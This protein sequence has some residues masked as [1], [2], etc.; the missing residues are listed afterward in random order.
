MIQKYTCW[1]MYTERV[2]F[3][4]EGMRSSF[5]IS[6]GAGG[7]SDG[8]PRRRS[9]AVGSFLLLAW[10]WTYEQ[11]VQ[12]QVQTC[13]SRARSHRRKTVS[14]SVSR[15][16]QGLRQVRKPQDSQTN[17]HRF[18]AYN[19]SCFYW[20]WNYRSRSGSLEVC[21]YGRDFLLSWFPITRYGILNSRPILVYVYIRIDSLCICAQDYTRLERDKQKGQRKRT[22]DRGIYPKGG[23]ESNIPHFQKWGLTDW[24][25]GLHIFDRL[26]SCC[27]RHPSDAYSKQRL[28]EARFV[29]F[30]LLINEYWYE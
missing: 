13:Q 2:I 24:S 28:F 30:F 26:A 4:T 1:C 7:T 5:R 3:N 21:W 19:D 14:L 15:L 18:V 23:W 10:M 25:L 27:T 6:D 12:S 17:P 29:N 16:R 9:R 8:G 11:A 20:K 22:G